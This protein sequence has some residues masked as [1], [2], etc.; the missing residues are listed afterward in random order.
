MSTTYDGKVTPGE[1][2]QTFLVDCLEVSKVAVDPKMSNNCYLLR[3][4]ETEEQILVDAAAA[5]GSSTPK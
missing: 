3:C 5:N 4:T 2:S 1:G